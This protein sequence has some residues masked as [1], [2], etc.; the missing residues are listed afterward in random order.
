MRN[1]I[2]SLAGR[3]AVGIVATAAILALFRASPVVALTAL[4]RGA[5]GSVNGVSES[6]LEA[7]PLLFTGLGV[8]LAFRCHLWN[9]GAEGQYLV[10]SLA[11][12]A[13]GVRA[14]GWPVWLL[15]PGV[16]AAAA[17]AGAAWA[18]VAAALRVYRGVPE[19]ISTIMLNFVALN[20][21]SWAVTGP[22]KEARQEIPRT[23]LLPEAARLAPLGTGGL[24]AGL[25]LAP[26]AVAVL[27]LFLFFTVSGF[28]IRAVGL[29]SAA[30]AAAGMP[31]RRTLMLGFTLS[32]ALAGLAA[33]VQLAGVTYRVYGG[34]SPGYGYTAIAVALVGQL[35]PVGVLLSA[36]FFG[37]L[38]AGSN[39]MQRTAGVSSVIAYVIQALAVFLLIAWPQPR[40]RPSVSPV[41]GR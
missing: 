40:V 41:E 37:A 25:L 32:G 28:R 13:L 5:V 22:L 33:G 1:H 19:V 15:L 14:A 8:A 6:L 4:V 30:A 7:T 26:V 34:S 16:L 12:V 18:A 2:V 11:G 24:H 21:V 9:I 29:N 39:E 23:P 3:L 36:L 17:M 10:G 20:L 35:H 27:M 38:V 31:V